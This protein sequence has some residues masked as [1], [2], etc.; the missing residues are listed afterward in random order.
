METN[1]SQLLRLKTNESVEFYETQLQRLWRRFSSHRLAVI[2]GCIVL[3]LLISAVFAGFISPHDPLDLDTSRRFIEPFTDI[4]FILGTDEMGRD[5]F[6]RLLHGGRISLIVG[7]AAMFATV[8]T[9]LLVGLVSGYYGGKIDNILMRFTD[10]ILCFPQVFLLLIL[11][12]FITPTVISIALIIG[13][14]S[15]MEVARI[16]RAQIQYIKK[17]DFIEASFALGASGPR[18]MFRELLPNAM[19][20]VLVS[21]TL[22]VANAVL[23]E[24]YISFLGYGIQPPLASWGNMLTNAQA[25]FDLSPWLA[26]LPGIMITLTVMSF[27]FLG[28]GLRD[29]LDP[30]LRM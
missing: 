30:R 21:A 6:A 9:G 5:T 1:S 26:I 16:I 14:T 20:P 15:W 4:H 13:F 10:T 19:A 3:T 2:G 24:S 23:M 27:N 17:Q 7:I 22:N 12:A 25:Y 11:A 8:V 29:A 28:D 18:I